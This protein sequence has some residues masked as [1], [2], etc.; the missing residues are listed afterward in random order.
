MKKLQNKHNYKYLLLPVAAVRPL[1]D[2]RIYMDKELAYEF[3]IPAAGG[4]ECYEFQYYAPL[5]LENG[6]GKEIEIEGDVGNAFLEAISF[7]DA[8]PWK[9]DSH[10]AVHFSANTGWLNDPNGFFYRDGVY[11]LYFQHN[12]FDTLW[13]NMSWGHAVSTDL[14]HWE[15]RDTVLYPDGDGTI[16]SGCALVDENRRLTFF[17]TSAGN[18]SAWSRDKK[19]TQKLAWSEDGGESVTKTD[20]VA[21]P[22]IAGDNRDPKVYWHE[23]TQAYVMAL[24]LEKNDFAIF[25]SK[26]LLHW[27]QS[28]RF[29][30]EDAWECP[31][32]LR[33]TSDEGETCWFFWSA[34]GFYYQGEFDGYKFRTQGK[35]Q[36][37]YINE[38]PYAAQTYFGVADR[39]I[40]IPWLRMKNDGRMFTGAYGIPVELTCKKAENGFI[41]IQRPVRELMQQAKQCDALRIESGDLAGQ[42]ENKKAFVL[43][44]LAKEDYEGSYVWEV[45]G[46]TIEYQPQSGQL[47]VDEDNYQIGCGYKEFLFLIVDRILEVFFDGGVQLGTFVLKTADIQLK[48]PHEA[49]AQY[50]VYEIL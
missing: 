46:S 31:D 9:A 15:Q 26:D 3:R 12:P 24:F 10:P 25:R 23:E 34:D 29:T 22:H 20:I 18:T 21:V 49:A 32:L 30:L 36:K 33:L 8:I 42:N 16:F 40:S 43:E 50:A 7:S 13:G 19:F 39:V 37:A 28:D 27:E 44:M 41:L 38:L 2:I 14:L 48:I 47:S 6:G 11:H 5:S 35:K 4:E 17:Y 1:K 45:N